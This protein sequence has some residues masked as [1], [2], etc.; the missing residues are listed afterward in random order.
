ML[1]ESIQGLNLKPD[2]IYVDLTF[3][4]GGHSREILKHLVGGRLIAF[5][6]DPDAQ[7]DL[8]DKR[9]QFFRANFRFLSHFLTYLEIDKVDGVLGDLGV[10]WHQFDMPE[11]GFSLRTDA[12][13][14]MRMNTRGGKPAHEL[15]NTMDETELA[16]IFLMYGEL[17]EGRSLAKAIAKARTNKPIL[18]T[19]DLKDSIA[20]LVPVQESN[21]YLA[22]VFQALRI[23]VNEEMK[24]LQEVLEQI[25]RWLKTDGRLVV[26]SYHSLEDRMVKN[27]MKTG[28]I[29]G[30]LEKD[31]FGRVS[32][33]F[34]P[35]TRKAVTP[36]E[37][38]IA[39]NPRS[40]SAKLR[41]A[42][43]I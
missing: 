15:I 29:E 32:L 39:S 25:P 35:L 3:G 10:S 33:P 16:H 17:H 41:I 12:L 42:E 43:R 14:D 24:C 21:K 34:R 28:N 27:F 13:L 36:G 26:I 18:T 19:G 5:D 38:E 11:R 20:S 30:S 6:Q 2:G 37:E 8:N 9:F 40:R 31:L 4:G 7:A 1:R 22:R 23:E